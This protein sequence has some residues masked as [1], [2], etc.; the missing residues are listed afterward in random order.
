MS[1]FITENNKL[2]IHFKSKD[3]EGS[4]SHN[5]YNIPIICHGYLDSLTVGKGDY[6]DTGQELVLYMFRALLF[7]EYKHLQK[8]VTFLID[9]VEVKFDHRMRTDEDN[10]PHSLFDECL[11]VLLGAEEN[12]F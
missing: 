2:I 7:S 12:D 11:C 8:Q 3:T 10:Y 4:K 9:G 1:R 6:V 5:D